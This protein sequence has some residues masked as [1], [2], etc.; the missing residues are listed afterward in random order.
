MISSLFTWLISGLLIL[1]WLP[2]LAFRR[3]FDR[4]PVLYSTGY[5]FRKLGKALTRV[6]PSW[7]LHISGETIANP[8]HP[9]VV[10]SNHKSLA[11]IPLISNLPW[12]M[13]LM[14]KVELFRLPVVGWMMKLAGDIAVDR[15]IARSGAQALLR[16]QHYLERKCSVMIFP[17]GTR[18]LDGRVRPFT[19]GA[20][21]LAIR[22]KMPILP[23]AIEGSREC[24]PKNS[25]RFGKPSDVH[26][27]VLPA[28]ETSSLTIDDVSALRERVRSSIMNEI[29][30]WRAVTI[31][32]VD[33][34]I[35]LRT[36]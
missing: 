27:K 12:E 31:D 10:V 4:D 18:T 21:H 17:E 7:R 29:A 14:G 9:Y 16:A 24:I 13:K 25:W 1:F 34:T 32:E 23:L 35:P 2:L 19:D 22:S 26:L 30:T 33:G 3:L 15:K 5:M 11:D 36:S 6:N 8:R 28:V 20:F